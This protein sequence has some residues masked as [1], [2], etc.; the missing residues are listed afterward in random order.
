MR[1]KRIS[2]KFSLFIKILFI[3]FPFLAFANDEHSAPHKENGEEVYV[4][5]N[6]SAKKIEHGKK[7]ETHETKT[8]N[9]VTKHETTGHEKDSKSEMHEIKAKEEHGSPTKPDAHEEHSDKMKE[10]KKD[11]HDN[12]K[13]ETKEKLKYKEN[14]VVTIDDDDPYEV[15]KPVGLFWFAGV[16]VTLLIV[17]FVFT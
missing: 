3:L 4:P 6:E 8:D 14:K 9:K 12:T 15:Q 17:I 10:D 16:F 7:E 1:Q 2:K 11:A 5:K 13:E